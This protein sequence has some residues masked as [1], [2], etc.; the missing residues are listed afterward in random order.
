M[1]LNLNKQFNLFIAQNYV[2]PAVTV[3]IIHLARVVF[4]F[5]IP[6]LAV[7]SLGILKQRYIEKVKENYSETGDSGPSKH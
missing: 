1:C 2:R 3:K 4:E 6:G 7:R 5:V